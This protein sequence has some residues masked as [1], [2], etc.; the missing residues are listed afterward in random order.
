M[1]DDRDRRICAIAAL[2][3]PDF[4][5][6]IKAMASA[7]QQPGGPV[8]IDTDERER[9]AARLSAIDRAHIV[10]AIRGQDREVTQALIQEGRTRRN[11][12]GN[13]D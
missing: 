8:C 9:I 3:L 10:S 4:L 5:A 11:R 7:S 2:P 6:A 12:N 13:Y 1:S